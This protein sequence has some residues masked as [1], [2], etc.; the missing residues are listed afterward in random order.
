MV[1][2]QFR[3]RVAFARTAVPALELVKL[4]KDAALLGSHPAD[5]DLAYVVNTPRSYRTIAFRLNRLA[6]QGCRS[7]GSLVMLVAVGSADLLVG[8]AGQCARHADQK[9]GATNVNVRDN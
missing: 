6:V 1:N 7:S 9:V 8:D 2:G 5:A 3:T 4:A